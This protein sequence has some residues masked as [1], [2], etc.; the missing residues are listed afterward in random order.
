MD[1]FF[2]FCLT[3]TLYIEEFKDTLNQNLFKIIYILHC[4]NFSQRYIS[5]SLCSRKQI[6]FHISV[7]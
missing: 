1:N 5:V 3:T 4:Y 2:N 6:T 7:R